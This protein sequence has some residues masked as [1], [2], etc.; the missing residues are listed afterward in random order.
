MTELEKQ[1]NELAA[2]EF[3]Y[4]DYKE[5]YTG[6][7]YKDGLSL[8]VSFLF[9]KIAELRTVYMEDIDSRKQSLEKLLDQSQ[10][11]EE[12]CQE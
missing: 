1:V 10:K 12:R 4:N 2:L 9:E 3:E 11:G 7:E 5:S 8:K 6:P